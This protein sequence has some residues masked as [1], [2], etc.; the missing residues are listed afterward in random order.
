MRS[1]NKLGSVY[2]CPVCGAEVSIMRHGEGS[3]GPY[4][5]NV[6]MELTD[7]INLIFRCPLCGTEIMAIKETEVGKLEPYCC[8]NLMMKINEKR[9]KKNTQVNLEA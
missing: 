4:C 6:A 3:L 9:K 2:R 1:A 5:C 7:Q 8:D